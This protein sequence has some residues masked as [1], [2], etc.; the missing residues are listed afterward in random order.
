[1]FPVSA[2]T[3]SS[4]FNTIFASKATP[5]ALSAGIDE[6]KVG[7]VVSTFPKYSISLI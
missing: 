4:K 5:V 3:N 6:V 2:S 1:M 7:F